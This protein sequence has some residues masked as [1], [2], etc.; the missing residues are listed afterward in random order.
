MSSRPSPALLRFARY[1]SVGVSTLL[2][3]LGML[4]IAVSI[5][6]IPYYLA[7]PCSFLLAISCN[8]MV[9][10]N[11]VFKG[12]QR[13]WHAG[14]AYFAI[15]ALFGAVATTGLVTVLVSLFGMY[16]LLARIMIAGI[17][18]MANYLFNLHINFKVV[19]KHELA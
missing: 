8:Y 5:F 9:S 3:D 19:G 13:S 2:L 7:T 4:Y 10:R 15:V 18:G 17:V 11:F 16:Y 1:A 6:G 14:Y 12:T